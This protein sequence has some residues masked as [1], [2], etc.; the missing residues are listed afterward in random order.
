MYPEATA[1]EWCVHATFPTCEDDN[2]P[3]EADTRGKAP[4]DKEANLAK[5]DLCG[6]DL[7]CEKRSRRYPVC[8]F[9]F[10]SLQNWL[11]C[12][13]SRPGIEEALTAVATRSSAPYN[14]M[15]MSDVHDAD[16][17][18]ITFAMYTDGIN[19]YGIWQA[20]KNASVTKNNGHCGTWMITATGHKNL[21][22]LPIGMLKTRY[23]TITEVSHCQFN[24]QSPFGPSEMALY[25]VLANV[26]SPHSDQ[27]NQDTPFGEM[28]FGTITNPSDTDFLLALLYINQ[29]LKGL[30]GETSSP[31]NYHSSFLFFWNDEEPGNQSLLHNFAHL[32]SLVNLALKQTMNKDRIDKYRNHFYEYI[33]SCLVLFPK[34]NLATNHPYGFT[35]WRLSGK[36]WTVPCVVPR[37]YYD[38][39]T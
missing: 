28:L 8:R 7:F 30:S 36:V 4:A 10:H 32:V 6:A 35:S 3:N 27:S 20:G 5:Q 17:S 34:S 21:Q 22:R 18:N 13:F 14:P 15:Q 29:K 25:K 12:L 26:R 31:F 1:L 37:S 24:A 2:E 33:K 38:P 16:A 39:G 23:W 9:V 11:A 19:S